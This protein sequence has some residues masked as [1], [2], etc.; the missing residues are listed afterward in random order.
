MRTV[1]M[2]NKV[3]ARTKLRMTRVTFDKKIATLVGL[4]RDIVQSKQ[5][6]QFSVRMRGILRKKERLRSE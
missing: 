1:H 3:V 4:E 2:F 5:H 6:Q